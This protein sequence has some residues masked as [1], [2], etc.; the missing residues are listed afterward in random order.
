MQ[1]DRPAATRYA[2]WLGGFVHGDLGVSAVSLAQG[3]HDTVWHQISGPLKNSA[4]LAAIAAFFMIPLSIGL[5]VIGPIYAGKPVDHA[6]SVLSLG[7]IALPEFV[8][9]SLLIGVFFVALDWLPPVAIV[10]PDGIAHLCE[11]LDVPAVDTIWGSVP[12]VPSPFPLPATSLAAWKASSASVGVR[13]FRTASIF[14]P[15]SGADRL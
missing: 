10:P 15:R 7:A 5:G 12:S 9:G 3:Q 1:L 2:D 4:I 8:T 6:I 13:A 14:P 11:H